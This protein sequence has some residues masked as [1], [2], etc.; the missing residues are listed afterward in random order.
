LTIVLSASG[1]L[2]IGM[3]NLTVSFAL[4]FYLALRAANLSRKEALPLLKRTMLAMLI[5][6]WLMFKLRGKEPTL[7]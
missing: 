4:A 1:V 5:A 6:P 3:M 7:E 2:M